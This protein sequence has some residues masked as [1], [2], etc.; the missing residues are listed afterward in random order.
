MSKKEKHGR[1]QNLFEGIFGREAQDESDAHRVDA[2]ES[3][4]REIDVDSFRDV[5][6]DVEHE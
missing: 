5:I 2:I 4:R 6:G 1:Y 3:L